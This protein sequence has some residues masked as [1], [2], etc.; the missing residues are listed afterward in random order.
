MGALETTLI[1]RT[2]EN[3]MSNLQDF[4]I[5]C[6]FC[7]PFGDSSIAPFD[8]FLSKFCTFPDEKIQDYNNKN[9]KGAVA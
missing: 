9:A 6:K 8:G 7:N 5:S 2:L 1:G 4:C 3:A